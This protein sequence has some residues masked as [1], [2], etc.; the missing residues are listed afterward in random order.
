MRY[1][2]VVDNGW[3]FDINN[4]NSRKLS[5]RMKK[6]TSM[7]V[8]TTIIQNTVPQNPHRARLNHFPW[9][10]QDH[11][12][13]DNG[14]WWI[15]IGSINIYIIGS[16]LDELLLSYF[17]IN[18]YYD[19]VGTQFQ[20]LGFLILFSVLI[21]IIYLVIRYCRDINIRQSCLSGFNNIRFIDFIDYKT[22]SQWMRY[23]LCIFSQRVR[24]LVHL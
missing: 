10:F 3:V 19:H 22:I 4:Y 20:Q 15:C 7:T 13:W 8:I 17:L 18:I 12:S 14:L 6:L 5:R 16:T 1:S 9:S 11:W 24:Y 23:L 2:K 21:G